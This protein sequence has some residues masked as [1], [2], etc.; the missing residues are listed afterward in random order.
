LNQNNSSI[1]KKRDPDLYD[2]TTGSGSV[3][4]KF[5]RSLPPNKLISLIC[6]FGVANGVRRINEVTL[7]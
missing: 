4:A 6:R 2:E 1:R 5:H 3:G 7:R